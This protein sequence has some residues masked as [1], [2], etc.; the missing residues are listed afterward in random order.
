MGFG[1]FSLILGGAIG[2]AL[3]RLYSGYVIDF[4]D[5]YIKSYHWPTFNIADTAICIGVIFLIIN[6]SLKELKVS[7]ENT[8]NDLNRQISS[9][10]EVV[11]HPDIRLK[12]GS[13]AESSRK[14]EKPLALKWEK[15]FSDKFESRF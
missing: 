9:D 15:R 1:R 10:S 14:M 4:V 2:N 13:I 12:D 8:N 6:E 11:M 7:K 3:N 5:L